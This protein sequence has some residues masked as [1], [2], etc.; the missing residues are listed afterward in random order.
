M[1]DTCRTEEKVFKVAASSNYKMPTLQPRIGFSIDSIVG[2]T[3]PKSPPHTITKPPPP[4]MVVTA[5]GDD[6]D[7]ASALGVHGLASQHQHLLQQHHH[8]QQ[9]QQHPSRSP[10]PPQSYSVRLNRLQSLSPPH[11]YSITRLPESPQSLEGGAAGGGGGGDRA[12]H[13]ASVRSLEALQSRLSPTGLPPQQPLSLKRH[14]S[15][16]PPASPPSIGTLGGSHLAGPR[17]DHAAH[18]AHTGHAPPPPP[19]GPIVVPGLP[20]GLVRPFPVSPSQQPSAPPPPSQGGPTQGGGGPA[21]PP[22]QPTELKGLPPFLHTP[23]EMM[24]AAHNQHFL[25]AQFQAAALAHAQAGQP[26]PPHP[27]AAH[28]HNPNLPPRDSYPLYPWLL[29]RHGRGVFPIGFPGNY[30]IPFRK[31]KR[32][33]TA[34]SPSQLLKLEHAFESNHYVVGAERKQLAQNLNLSETQVKVWFQNR[35]TKHKRMQQEEGGSGSGK[36][37]DGDHQNRSASSPTGSCEEDD[38][39]DE[40]IDM[41]DCPSDEENMHHNG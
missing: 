12:G 31:S 37:T 38:E 33:R 25:A 23:Q 14:R 8:Q 20:A 39:E 22:P 3:T 16:S 19:T 15:P 13:H 7:R 11:N 35:R 41:D 24:Q 5:T 2:N 21:P 34:F 28:L 10:S 36:S 17:V 6:R 4:A 32:V 27:A 18:A 9:Q 26:F 1:I 40:F 30:L 29:S